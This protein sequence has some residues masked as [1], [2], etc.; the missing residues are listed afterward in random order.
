MLSVKSISLKFLPLTKWQVDKESLHQKFYEFC[1]KKV[2]S[3]S[4]FFFFS[5]PSSFHSSIVL[6]PSGLFNGATSFCQLDILSTN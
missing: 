6:L 2:N 5:N 1:P 4:L 3:V